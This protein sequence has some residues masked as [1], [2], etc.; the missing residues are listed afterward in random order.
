M[1]QLLLNKT[2]TFIATAPLLA[3]GD[4]SYTININSAPLNG[5]LF[6]RSLKGLATTN[7]ATISTPP[8]LGTVSL[9]RSK[10]LW[11]YTPNNN[12]S[13]NDSFTIRITDKDGK[14]IDHTVAITIRPTADKHTL[15][16]V[17]QEEK[18][19]QKLN[20]SNLDTN[21]DG[22]KDSLQDTIALLPWRSKTNFENPDA[23]SGLI[24]MLLPDNSVP[25]N[26]SGNPLNTPNLNSN[27]GFKGIEVLAANDPDVGGSTPAGVGGSWDPLSFSLISNASVSTPQTTRVWIDLSS[28]NYP[29]SYF[30]G[31]RKYISETTIQDYQVANL[32]LMDLSGKAITT[33]GWYDFNQRRDA[34][35]NPVGDGARL[36][37]RNGRIQGLE[38][39]LTDNAFGDSDPTLGVIKDPGSLVLAPQIRLNPGQLSSSVVANTTANG[40]P[41]LQFLAAPGQASQFRLFSPT[42]TINSSGVING[43][44]LLAGQHYKVEEITIDADRSAYV[45][46]FLDA[47]TNKVGNQFFG[48]FFQGLATGN[49]AAFADGLYRLSL[50]DNIQLGSFTL[51]TNQLSQS[52]YNRLS[53]FHALSL[54]KNNYSYFSALYG[55]RNSNAPSNGDDI[56]IGKSTAN[57]GT[58]RDTLNGLAGNDLI[59]GYGNR[60]NPALDF[61]TTTNP[62]DQFGRNQKDILTG[63][64]G[65]DIFQLADGLGAFYQGDGKD[66]YAVITDFSADDALILSGSASDYTLS[67]AL[68]AQ[69]SPIGVAG[70]ALYLGSPQ[71]GDLI[72]ILQ[73]SGS[74]ALQLNPTDPSRNQIQWL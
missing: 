61:N 45:I 18:L 4:D 2:N 55:F 44:P 47:D 10:D 1:P 31:Y 3:M 33:A 59:N 7:G 48:S 36:I 56:L 39:T 70:R 27:W 57:A 38:L 21:G 53:C 22:Q 62:I 25:I 20:A 19:A 67:T 5:D 11:T 58:S 64:A 68:T 17:L 65:R 66:G 43:S 13:G 42:A 41:E 6:I 54:Q 37:S 8:S 15:I 30:N 12:A 69:Q 50:G 16:T 73:G 40:L 34:N 23:S 35:G 60:F 24:R 74:S 49:S 51:K 32:P 46:Q 52:E 28:G 14:Q 72:A 71:S 63:G 29:I 9:D 26:P